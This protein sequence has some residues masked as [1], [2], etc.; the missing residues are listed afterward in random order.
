VERQ[1]PAG[2]SLRVSELIGLKWGDIHENS[3]TA[4]L[5]ERRAAFAARQF[6]TTPSVVLSIVIAVLRLSFNPC[7]GAELAYL[8]AVDYL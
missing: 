8:E 6:L 1:H 2:A 7:R 3:R 5:E 4:N